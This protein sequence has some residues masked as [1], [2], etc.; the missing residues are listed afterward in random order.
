MRLEL[1]IDL[2][3]RIGGFKGGDDRGH[4]IARLPKD[5]NS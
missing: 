2:D 4:D 5:P 3:I 1:V